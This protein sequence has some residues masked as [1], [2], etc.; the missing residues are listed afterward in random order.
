MNSIY[1]IKIIFAIIAFILLLV[2]ASG[3]NNGYLSIGLLFI[4]CYL[5]VLAAPIY[6]IQK[7]IYFFYLILIYQITRSGKT[8][9][10]LISIILPIN[11]Q[12]AIFDGMSINSIILLSSIF[13]LIL[14]CFPPLIIYLMIPSK[15]FDNQKKLSAININKE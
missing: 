3:R 9:S 10:I 11:F 1:F 15:V 2:V 7:N 12:I 4:S 6:K 14:S 13:Q 5:H 8:I